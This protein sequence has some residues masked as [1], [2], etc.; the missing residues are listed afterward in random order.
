[1]ASDRS[2]WG[3]GGEK[4]R[5]H[6]HDENYNQ[7]HFENAQ[8]RKIMMEIMMKG[9]DDT[10]DDDLMDLSADAHRDKFP[11]YLETSSF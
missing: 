8:W 10:N 5:H 4:S 11:P 9:A 2:I 3:V 1:M 6:I 7:C